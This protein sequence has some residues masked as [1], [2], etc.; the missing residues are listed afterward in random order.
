MGGPY[1]S[2]VNTSIE[3]RLLY[4]TVIVL[5]YQRVCIVMP[6]Q[7]HGKDGEGVPGSLASWQRKYEYG[8]LF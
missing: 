6:A 7:M 4:L 5:S 8:V 3:R 2:L 1:D